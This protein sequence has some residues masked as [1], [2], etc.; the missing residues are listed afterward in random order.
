MMLQGL[1]IMVVG[2]GMVVSFLGLLVLIMQ[3]SSRIIP[4]FN[5][6]LPDEGPRV[7]TRKATQ[8]N[9]LNTH[10]SNEE[11]IAVAIAAAFACQQGRK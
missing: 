1:V 6:I 3:L 10:T 11:E 4:R 2:V 9:A 8:G 7:K 5:H